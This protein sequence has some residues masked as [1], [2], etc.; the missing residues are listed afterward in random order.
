MFSKFKDEKGEFLG[1]LGNDLQGLLS[2]YE[3]AYMGCKGEH[4][5][6]EAIIF[7]T[8]HLKSLS[9]QLNL[10]RTSQVRK[11]LD[12]PLHKRIPRIEA[13]YYMSVYENMEGSEKDL[14]LQLAKLDF[15]GLQLL[16]QTELNQLT[17]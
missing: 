3:A 12:L 15:I 8:R 10:D 7:S 5:L 1:C 2:L 6:E 16:H 14:L 9:S 4:I 11:S 13:T 17:R